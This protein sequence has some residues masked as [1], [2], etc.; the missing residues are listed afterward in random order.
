[1]N[2]KEKIIIIEGE[3]VE[4]N[5]LLTKTKNFLKKFLKITIGLSLFL[6][7]LYL[8]IIVSIF[9]IGIFLAIGVI[10]FIAIKLKKKKKYY[11]MN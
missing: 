1:M 7:I 5:N 3:K 4:E 11:K 6:G 8:A 2:Q 9:L 10:S